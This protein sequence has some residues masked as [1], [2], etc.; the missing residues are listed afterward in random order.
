MKTTEENQLL[1]DLHPLETLNISAFQ[2][3]FLYRQTPS[4]LELIA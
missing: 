3:V 2:V 1:D 4:K